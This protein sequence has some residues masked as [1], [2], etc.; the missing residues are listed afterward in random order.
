VALR[1]YNQFIRLPDSVDR[2]NLRIFQ[3][4][5]YDLA[6]PDHIVNSIERLA[7][8]ASTVGSFDQNFTTWSAPHP[9]FV[10]TISFDVRRLA[11]QHEKLLYQVVASTLKM[12]YL[13]LR[14][15]W[16]H[17]PDEIEVVIDSWM[18]PGHAVTLLWRQV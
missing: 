17:V 11:R 15:T 18:L 7:M 16:T 3:L 8:R 1:N 6:D 4:D 9:C 12:S 5:L 10:H 13:P 2:K 14:G